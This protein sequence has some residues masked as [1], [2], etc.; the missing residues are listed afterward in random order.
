[1]SQFKAALVTACLCGGLAAP[2]FAASTAVVAVTLDTSFIVL[3]EFPGDFAGSALEG[4][5]P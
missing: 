3:G 5:S 1:M 2:A 4:F